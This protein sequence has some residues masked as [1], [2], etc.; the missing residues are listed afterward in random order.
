MPAIEK[1]YRILF[2]LCVEI[3]INFNK[4]APRSF[5]GETNK[6]SYFCAALFIFDEFSLGMSD[7]ILTV[8][9]FTDF[10]IYGL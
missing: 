4:I 6:N 9:L 3:I 1:N 10:C 5:L 2:V 8:D 7:G